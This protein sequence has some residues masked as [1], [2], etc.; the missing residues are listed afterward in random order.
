M[1][2]ET[3]KISPWS[4]TESHQLL[5][6]IVFGKIKLCGNVER[7][8]DSSCLTYDDLRRLAY[9][10]Q[11]EFAASLD[12]EPNDTDNSERNYE[13][14]HSFDVFLMEKNLA[15]CNLDIA[16]CLPTI[17]PKTQTTSP[18]KTVLMWHDA[19]GNIWSIDDP[20]THIRKLTSLSASARILE[21]LLLGDIPSLMKAAMSREMILHVPDL[22]NNYCGKDDG[23]LLNESQAQAVAAVASPEFRDGFLVIQGPPGTGK[24]T[25]MVD[26]IKAVGRH[27][28]VTAPS[29]AAVANV[30]LKLFATNDY[31]HRDVC[32]FGENCHESVRFLSPLHRGQQHYEFQKKVDSAQL[33]EEKEKLRRTFAYWLHTD[34]DTST[35]ESMAMNCPYIDMENV[36][37][38]RFFKREISSC[39]VIFCTLN[40]AG[41]S[42]LRGA[43]RGCFHTL[44]LD[45]G[46]QCPEAEFYI[47]TTVPGVKRIVVVGDP[48][49]LPSTVIDPLNQRA[50]YGESWMGQVH[51]H[52]HSTVHLLNIQYRMDPAILLFPNRHFYSDQIRSGGNVYGRLPFVE[53]PFQFI[54][55]E[56]TGSQEKVG[57]SWRNSYEAAVIKSMIKTDSDIKRIRA[58]D[59]NARIIIITPYLAQT[60][61]LKS[62]FEN[63]KGLGRVDVATVDSFQGQEGDIVIISTVRTK[64]VGFLD[65]RHRLNVALTR[66]KRILRIV[67]N[68]TFFL[69]LPIGSTLRNIALH[70]KNAS[71][72]KTA[73][74]KALAWRSPDW[75]APRLW[76]VLLTQRFHYIIKTMTDC[77]RNIC[78][79]TLLAV[80][81]PDT[82]ALYAR[83]VLRQVP[84]WH[85]S[86]L[87]GYAKELQIVWIAKPGSIEVHFAG[88]PHKCHHFL[89]TNNEVPAGACLVNSGLSCISLPETTVEKGFKLNGIQCLVWTMTNNLQSSLTQIKALPQGSFCL[90]DNQSSVITAAPP[91][92]IESRSG[93]GKTNVL[94]QHAISHAA[95]TTMPVCFVTVSSRLSKELKTRFEEVL[96]VEGAS[97]PQ[98]VFYSFRNIVQDLL[99]TIGDKVRNVMMMCTFHDY[100]GSR[101][102]HSSTTVDITLTENEI[103][104]VILGSL[105][106]ALQKAPLTLEQYMAEKRSNIGKIK[107]DDLKR[108]HDVYKEFMQYQRWKAENQR[109][110]ISDII[111]DILDKDLGVYFDSGKFLLPTLDSLWCIP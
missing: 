32:V 30:A 44:L 105:L 82:R 80:A 58:A 9:M 102:A 79:N 98:I 59:N 110:D 8:T 89:Q 11:V 99:L 45:E 68:A 111:L 100:V 71:V 65:N 40:V 47:A 33:D 95:G 23:S 63:V 78:L 5:I 74:L 49:Q 93:T 18:Q 31:S 107:Q 62:N 12:K 92:L 96:V 66:S 34:P 86:A 97:L 41:S 70:A 17:V 77:Q 20:K 36:S 106:A 61:L 108:R 83:P 64:G 87:T 60:E 109:F 22:G 14:P 21:N 94:F 90:D 69:S 2:D 6:D 10:V 26:M 16:V 104:G 51:K 55:T 35:I 42:F 43:L 27:I 101:K 81:T 57:F 53:N 7:V 52:Y 24:T 37:G 38:R 50:G 19:A 48:M 75:A 56:K 91:L 73:T 72:T 3:H 13:S 85:M 76:A 46:G 28:I 25:T 15:R 54:D 88:P 39:K 103:G 29:N 67:G 84:S 1:A 4:F